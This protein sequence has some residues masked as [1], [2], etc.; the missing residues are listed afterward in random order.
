MLA[1]SSTAGTLNSKS[2]VDSLSNQ[3]LYLDNYSKN[4]Y[5]NGGTSGSNLSFDG[6]IF[7]GGADDLLNMDCYGNITQTG[8]LLI[9]GAI[10]CLS[11]FN[12]SGPI[13][14]SSALTPYKINLCGGVYGFGINGSTLLYNSG[15]GPSIT[16]LPH[17][18]KPTYI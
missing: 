1:S 9:G 17:V 4:Y 7:R 5:R 18:K 16:N 13:N 6:H 11:T 10:S 2:W 14:F 8:A 12:I 15:G 3:R